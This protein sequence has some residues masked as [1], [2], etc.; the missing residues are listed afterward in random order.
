MKRYYFN[1]PRGFSNEFSI[2]SV[3]QWS[4]KECIAF[5]EFEERYNNSPDS[6]RKLYRISAKE[7]KTIIAMEKRLKKDYLRA[8]LNLS[9]NPVGATE[10]ITATEFFNL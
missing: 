5:A 1:S 4:V 10:I 6:N 8:G 7:A 9:E 3:D 2:I